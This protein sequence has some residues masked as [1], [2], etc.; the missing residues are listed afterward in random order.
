M[1]RITE[2]VMEMA[3][4]STEIGDQTE[5]GETNGHSLIGGTSKKPEPRA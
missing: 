1:E 2:M 5:I 3:G 4:D